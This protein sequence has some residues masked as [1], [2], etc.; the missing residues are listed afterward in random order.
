MRFRRNSDENIRDLERQ[1]HATRGE[2]ELRALIAAYLRSNTFPL[3][4]LL[5]NPQSF[6]FLPEEMQ[7]DL[8]AIVNF[9]DELE[10]EL[11]DAQESSEDNEEDDEDF[12]DD[13]D[14]ED[15]VDDALEI[16]RERGE[17]WE[18]A[19]CGDDDFYV[20]NQGEEW[21]ILSEEAAQI[22]NAKLGRGQENAAMCEECLSQ[23]GLDL[24]QAASDDLSDEFCLECGETHD[25][26]SCN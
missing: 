20:G 7:D 21:Q 26:C 16:A 3:M 19:N 15:E 14:N 1:Y 4:F 23:A 2:Q 22:T 6:Q 13:E 18:C 9:Q 5:E 17:V 12:E 24:E 8:R 25:D 10:E 11:A